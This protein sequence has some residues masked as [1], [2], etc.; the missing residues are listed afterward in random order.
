MKTTIKLGNE[1]VQTETF[2]YSTLEESFNVYQ[3]NVPE[4]HPMFGK[5]IKVKCVV[6]QMS[7]FGLD[8]LGNP[9]VAISSD[10]VVGLE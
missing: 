5:T 8:D 3:P 7:F 2:P 9:K 6:K 4:G 10:N 1:T